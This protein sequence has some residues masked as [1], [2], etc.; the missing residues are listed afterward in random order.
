M[1]VVCICLCCGIPKRLARMVTDDKILKWNVIY[2]D[3][4]HLSESP[5]LI[6]DLSIYD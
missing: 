3:Y 2:A 6:I 5:M 4:I 1:F